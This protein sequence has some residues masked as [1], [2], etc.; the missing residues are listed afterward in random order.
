MGQNAPDLW[1]VYMDRAAHFDTL[2]TDAADRGELLLAIRLFRMT[3]FYVVMARH[4]V[5]SELPS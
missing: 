5:T 3:K 2:G 4:T 1:D